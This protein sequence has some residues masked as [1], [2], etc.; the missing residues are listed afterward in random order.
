VNKFSK[1]NKNIKIKIKRI[2]LKYKIKYDKKLKKII[3]KENKNTPNENLIII[4]NYYF[5]KF[6]KDIKSKMSKC[7]YRK[8]LEEIILKEDYF[9]KELPYIWKLRE[10]KIRCILKIIEKKIFKSESQLNQ[11]I[12]SIENWCNKIEIE[13]K[14]WVQNLYEEKLKEMEKENETE[15]ENEKEKENLNT[16]INTRNY[17]EQIESL[18]YLNL[19]ELYLLALFKFQIK[20]YPEMVSFLG[21]AE[22]L[23]KLFSSVSNSSKFLNAAQKVS[24]FISNLFISDK[25][26]ASA[27]IYQEQVFK[28]AYKELFLRIDED[29]GFDFENSDIGTQHEYNKIFLNLTKAFYHRGI[30][31]EN[32]GNLFKA[33]LSYKQ[34]NYYI[35]YFQF[36]KPDLSQ[37]LT[38][39]F[40]RAK[41][42]HFLLE[43]MRYRL[44]NQDQ[45]FQNNLTTQNNCNNQITIHNKDKEKDKDRGRDKD[46]DN[47]RYNDTDINKEK[48]KNKDK[49]YYN[50]IRLI[51]PEKLISQL[52]EEKNQNKNKNKVKFSIDKN[53]NENE[54]ENEY[55]NEKNIITNTNKNKNINTNTNNKNYNIINR[56]RNEKEKENEEL[57]ELINGLKFQEFEFIEDDEKSNIIKKLMST[58]NLLNN[59]SSKK[60]KDIL[61]EASPLSIEKFNS[62]LFEKI[63]KRLNDIRTEKKFTEMEKDKINIKNDDK[64]IIKQDIKKEIEKY[65]L[66]GNLD[67][68]ENKLENLGINYNRNIKLSKQNLLN[69]ESLLTEKL[70]QPSSPLTKSLKSNYKLFSDIKVSQSQNENLC[71]IINSN[72]NSN[73]NRNTNSY[74]NKNAFANGNQ[75]P[76]KLSY[77]YCFGYSNN[78]RNTNPN[79]NSERSS[80]GF[81]STSMPKI[82]KDNSK[83][84]KKYT[85]DEYI[86]SN[87]YQDKLKKI[88]NFMK[89]ELDFQK[90]LLCL[91]R[92]EKIPIEIKEINQNELKIDAKKFFDK[93]KLKCELGNIFKE[94]PIVKKVEKDLEKN[95]KIKIKQ[96]LEKTLITSCDV[97]IFSIFKKIK[98]EEEKNQNLIRDEFLDKD[99]DKGKIKS[100]EEMEKVISE[101]KKNN[102]KD[103][104]FLEKKEKICKKIISNDDK[105]LRDYL[106]NNKKMHHNTNTNFNKNFNNN[107]EKYDGNINVLSARNKINKNFNLDEFVYFDKPNKEKDSMISLDVNDDKY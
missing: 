41:S 81:Y 21:I 48:D 99:N 17:D 89:K 82:K 84:V 46:E 50:T 74:S 33:T 90:E 7:E 27:N 83:S 20:Q 4:Q 44:Y 32:Q 8:S 42:S 71:S 106:N 77:D 16:N 66:K 93:T 10:L 102:E 43:K 24:L 68:K 92:V 56:N 14:N 40:A 22:K 53:E 87:K 54:N 104:N 55:D 1:V 67:N 65:L 97:K 39:L 31:Q 28:L 78:Y 58:I 57:N 19:E 88:D 103:L 9:F 61:K 86:L 73:S 30:C 23:I 5:E 72:T 29:E 80:K 69:S 95:K 3:K 26:Y 64:I 34:A 75:N 13:I 101:F 94:K 2:Q 60:F 11:K 91:K 38:D 12:K 36:Q 63:Q 79:T 18:M 35:K 25:D 107:E 37:Y 59:L 96:K 100:L 51:K 45:Y 15:N 62:E 47:D 105:L 85:H 98:I 6:F 49:N 52:K 70:T 76:R